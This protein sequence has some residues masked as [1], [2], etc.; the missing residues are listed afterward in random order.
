MPAPQRA[1]S[2]IGFGRVGFKS[3]LV[4]R[5]EVFVGVVSLLVRVVLVTTVW[6]AVYAGRAT[7]ADVSQETAVAY[8]VLGA[9]FSSVLNPWQFSSLQMRIRQ[10]TIAIDLLRP[11]GLVPQTLAQQVG[12]TIASF[13]RGILAIA[14]G[15]VIGALAPPAGGVL[16]GAAFVL[17]TLLGIAVA[18]LLNLIVSMTAFWTLEIGGAMIVYRMFVS[19]ASGALIPLWFMPG[20]IRAV[21]EWLPFQAQTFVPL[22]IYFGQT[23]G[24]AV[25]VSLLGQAGWVVALVMLTQLVWWRAKHRVVVNGG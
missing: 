5:S 16:G 11:I 24:S 20:P 23:S 14:L 15:I 4:F 7:V 1:A 13:P 3:V 18:L 22:S 10:G 17:S 12:T 9:V 8:A 21:L 19:F 25:V 2:L 6:H